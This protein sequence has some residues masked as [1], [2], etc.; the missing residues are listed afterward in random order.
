M[1][2]ELKQKIQNQIELANKRKAQFNN[3]Q[4]IEKFEKFLSRQI[5]TH[6]KR[7][8]E[9]DN[10]KESYLESLYKYLIFYTQYGF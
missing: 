2:S 10:I 3:D 7:M 1:N 5:D 4:I 8:Q 9:N 6:K